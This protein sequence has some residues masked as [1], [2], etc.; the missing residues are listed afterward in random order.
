MAK[1]LPKKLVKTSDVSERLR[2]ALSKRSKE[3]LIA[4]LVELAKEDHNILRQIDARFELEA[5]LVELV[6]AT[7]RAIADA[8]DFDERDANYNFDYDHAAYDEVKRNLARLVKLKQLRQAME[9]SLELM[10]A[11]SQQVEMSDEGLMTEEIEECLMVVVKALAK[12]DLPSDEKLAWC[13]AMT[14]RDRVGFLCDEE[15]QSLSNRIGAA[16]Q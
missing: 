5:P 2:K 8:T 4:V 7:R 12:C 6:A 9:L 15:I 16:R 13:A 14:K 1:R 3:D 10:S 11:G